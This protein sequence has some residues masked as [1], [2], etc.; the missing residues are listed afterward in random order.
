MFS[1]HVDTSM[2]T[3]HEKSLKVTEKTPNLEDPYIELYNFVWPHLYAIA[4][5]FQLSKTFQQTWKSE[6]S[7]K[8]P[9]NEFLICTWLSI[10]ETRICTRV[11]I[12]NSHIHLKYMNFLHCNPCVILVYATIVSAT[13][14]RLLKMSKKYEFWILGS[15]GSYATNSFNCNYFVFAPIS[16]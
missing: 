6:N 15:L 2:T 13:R 16:S 5:I 10:K 7:Q 1:S 8:Y 12:Y 9:K 14:V 11:A 4:K 3:L